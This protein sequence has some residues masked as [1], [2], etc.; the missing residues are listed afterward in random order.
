MNEKILEK[1]ET[2]IDKTLDDAMSRIRSNPEHALRVMD[3]V[4]DTLKTIDKIKRASIRKTNFSPTVDCGL[5]D[6]K[7]SSFN[8]II[9]ALKQGQK[10]DTNIT[11]EGLKG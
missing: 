3:T 10:P 4:T 1:L 2:L 6:V 5:Y 7:K 8:K 11:T 9:E